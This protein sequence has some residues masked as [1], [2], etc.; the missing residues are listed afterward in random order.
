M[1][2]ESNHWDEASRN[3]KEMLEMIDKFRRPKVE[4]KEEP[5]QE[6][7]DTGERLREYDR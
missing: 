4:Y 1:T 6:W 7:R 3:L 2:K 5:N